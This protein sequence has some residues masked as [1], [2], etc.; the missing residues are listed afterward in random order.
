MAIGEYFCFVADAVNW[1]MNEASESIRGIT[2]INRNAIAPQA[3]D[4]LS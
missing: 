4:L 3:P 2:P 1:L